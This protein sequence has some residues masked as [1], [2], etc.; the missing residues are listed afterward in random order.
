MIKFLLF[1]MLSGW[2][3]RIDIMFP[4][5]IFQFC[6]CWYLD[7]FPNLKIIISGKVDQPFGPENKNKQT[8]ILLYVYLVC[9]LEAC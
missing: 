2:A 3:P 7:F 4:I 1:W 9:N 6:F 5:L 8:N